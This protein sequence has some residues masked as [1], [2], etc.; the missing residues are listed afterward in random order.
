MAV[1]V[2]EALLNDP[3]NG[4]F[5]ILLETSQILWQLQIDSDLAAFCKPLQV[6]TKTRGEPN[7]IEQG[8][9]QQMR[10]GAQFSRQFLYK[11]NTLPDCLGSMGSDVAVFTLH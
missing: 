11:T 5:R 1:N 3:K 6:R 2:R 8:W 9:M 7:F 10:D 4:G